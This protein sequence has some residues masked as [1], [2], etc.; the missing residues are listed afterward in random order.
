MSAG[1][2]NVSRSSCGHCQREDLLMAPPISWALVLS[3]LLSLVQSS[4][5][6]L[7]MSTLNGS[8]FLLLLDSYSIHVSIMKDCGTPSQ[9]RWPLLEQGDLQQHGKKFQGD[10]IWQSPCG[11]RSFL[12]YFPIVWSQCL[13]LPPAFHSGSQRKETT[14]T[15]VVLGHSGS[16]QG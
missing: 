10:R 1:F 7:L 2:E 8:T 16:F 12:L 5:L 6:L 15:E 3:S 4:S 14:S 9:S 13:G 11:W